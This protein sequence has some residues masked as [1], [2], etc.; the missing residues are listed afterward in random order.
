MFTVACIPWQSVQQLLTKLVVKESYIS[1]S[2]RKQLKKCSLRGTTT[3]LNWVGRFA[4]RVL[5]PGDE[6]LISI[7]E[8]PPPMSF[9]GKKL[10]RR[11][12]LSLSM[13]T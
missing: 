6:V 11:R 1:L 8:A 13:P 7:V 2:M 9:L 5:E 10:V 12:V 3:G 4:E